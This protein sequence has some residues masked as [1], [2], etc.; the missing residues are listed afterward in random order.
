[1]G[2]SHA[3]LIFKENSVHVYVQVNWIYAPLCY[4]YCACNIKEKDLITVV[5]VHEN[6]LAGAFLSCFTFVPYMNIIY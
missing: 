5:K 2:V 1:M 3:S 6:Q 4:F